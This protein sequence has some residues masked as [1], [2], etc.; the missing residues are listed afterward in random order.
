[1]YNIQWSLVFY[2]PLCQSL[3]PPLL[4]LWLLTMFFLLLWFGSF[5]LKPFLKQN[6]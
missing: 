4:H 6:F 3:Y 2:E 5:D 1:M